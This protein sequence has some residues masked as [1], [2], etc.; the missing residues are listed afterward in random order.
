MRWKAIFFENDENDDTIPQKYGLNTKH[1]PSQVKEMI[2]F[3]NE[4]ILTLSGISNSKKMKTNFK[5]S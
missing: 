1:T 3:E 2:E 5:P 4:L